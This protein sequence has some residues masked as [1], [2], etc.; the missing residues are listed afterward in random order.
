MTIKQ[1]D[2]ATRAL[3]DAAIAAGKVTKCPPGVFAIDA[4]DSAALQWKKG[5]GN[6]AFARAKA[7]LARKQAAAQE[8]ETVDGL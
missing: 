5:V 7:R 2:P 3:I 8:Q 1:V 4:N 6:T